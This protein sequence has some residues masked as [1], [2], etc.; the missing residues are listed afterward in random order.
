MLP[1]L[2]QQAIDLSKNVATLTGNA[3]GVATRNQ[4]NLRADRLTW[5]IDNQQ[6][7]G[8]GNVRYQQQDPTLTLTGVKGVGKLQDQSVVVTG[9][10]QQ[11]VETQIIPTDSPTTSP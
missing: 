9:N 5:Q 6:I 10:S 2:L 7:V 4:A 11:L 1:C 8:T 3:H